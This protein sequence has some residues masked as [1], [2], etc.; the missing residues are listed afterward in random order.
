MKP[1]T[2]TSSP[3]PTPRPSSDSHSPLEP[4]PLEAQRV[5]DPG[6]G[7][8]LLLDVADLGPER[9]IVGAAVSAE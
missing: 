6:E 3:G 5:P 7:G 4:P 8:D 1:G 2:M 9:R